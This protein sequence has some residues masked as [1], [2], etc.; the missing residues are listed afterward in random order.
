M[1]SFQY[2]SHTSSAGSRPPPHLLSP[3]SIT[4]FFSPPPV[5]NVPTSRRG[6]GTSWAS[7]F[8]QFLVEG[9]SQRRLCSGERCPVLEAEPLGGSRD[10]LT[11]GGLMSLSRALISF[12]PRVKLSSCR[13]SLQ[14]LARF[15]PSLFSSTLA[16][17][18]TF[19]AS[20]SLIHFVKRCP[21]PPPPSS[22]TSFP[23]CH[24]L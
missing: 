21:P 13:S 23:A 20:F 22:S 12:S 10:L 15:P 4:R 1:P 6:L 19:C 2:K 18:S 8:A 24:R 17:Q 3:P 9:A 7:V 11:T 16:S 5:H 14:A